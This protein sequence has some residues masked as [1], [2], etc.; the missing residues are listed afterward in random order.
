M[1]TS[2][3]LGVIQLDHP[4]AYMAAKEARRENWLRRGLDITGDLIQKRNQDV[5]YRRAS[6]KKDD[7]N[8]TEDSLK[9]LG[10]SAGS[11]IAEGAS[12]LKDKWDRLDIRSPFEETL[13]ES[14]KT[15]TPILETPSEKGSRGMI[16]YTPNPSPIVEQDKYRTQLKAPDRRVVEPNDDL[17][18]GINIDAEEKPSPIIPF[19]TGE[20][21]PEQIGTKVDFGTSEPTT[22]LRFPFAMRTN[23]EMEAQKPVSPVAGA[24]APAKQFKA[25]TQAPTQGQASVPQGMLQS[26]DWSEMF[27]LN[28][29]R[30]KY[31]W[32]R[33][34]EGTA[35]ALDAAKLAQ[36][37]GQASSLEELQQLWK[38]NTRALDTARKNQDSVGMKMYQDNI[39][40]LVPLLQEKAPAV[41]G[42]A[43]TPASAE[44]DPATTG[45]GEGADGTTHKQ[46]AHTEAYTQVDLLTDADENGTLDNLLAVDRAIKG[47]RD[48]YGVSDADMQ[49]VYAQVELAKSKAKEEKEARERDLQIALDNK[50]K[51]EAA[52]RS[53]GAQDERAAL[54]RINKLQKEP[55]PQNKSDAILW[56]MRKRSGAKIDPDEFLQ[57]LKGGVD[58]ATYAEITK[59]LSP[60]GISVW[61]GTLIDGKLSESQ[62]RTITDKYAARVNPSFLTEDLGTFVDPDKLNK[63]PP[64][65]GGGKPPPGGDV[66]TDAKGRKYTVSSTGE[67]IYK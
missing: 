28:P 53:G 59:D 51:N 61:L 1:A 47:I 46:R 42:K 32:T 19:R 29:E 23:E 67:R 64:G 14:N 9:K 31:D 7:R 62:V 39:D 6:G 48:K 44:T 16:G 58:D 5:R 65:G 60:S 54:L 20:Q 56:V 21:I 35:L 8:T 17:S 37:A 63:P 49:D 50:L 12:W 10:E 33:E 2:P 38:D 13:T 66:K 18:F 30:A 26:P 40:R 22:K 24:E 11:K 57:Y 45:A 25:Q 41:W 27:R 52:A 34:R 55:T 43:A 3:R 36:K 15:E 4:N